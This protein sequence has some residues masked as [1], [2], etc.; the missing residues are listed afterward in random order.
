MK[1]IVFIAYCFVKIIFICVNKL[2]TNIYNNI[3]IPTQIIMRPQRVKKIPG[4]LRTDP[5]A[6]ARQ[7]C[8]HPSCM[9][10][11]DG[12]LGEKNEDCDVEDARRVQPGKALIDNPGSNGNPNM[13]Y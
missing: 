7:T 12:L 9:G 4:K 2:K 1:R 13:K 5:P 8:Y 3:Y 6:C 10:T 11:G